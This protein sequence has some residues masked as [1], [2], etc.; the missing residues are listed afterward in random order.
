M[1]IFKTECFGPVAS[2]IKAAD[3]EAALAIANDSD[4]GLSSAVIT[5]D[6]QKAMAI[7]RG[8]E[9]GMCH[10]NGPTVRD[11]AVVPFGGIKHS[12]LGREGGRYAMEEVTEVKWVTIQQGQQQYPF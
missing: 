10:I 11:E 4:Y 5:N 6:L 7:S 2:V 9:S 12:G 8:I 3:Y 1:S